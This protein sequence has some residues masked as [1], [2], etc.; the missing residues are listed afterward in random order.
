MFMYKCGKCHETFKDL[1]E[2]LIRCPH[3]AYK[4]LYKTR[5]KVTK[6][7]KAR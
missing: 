6:N 4:I 2:G 1:P 7:I 5:P 3:C